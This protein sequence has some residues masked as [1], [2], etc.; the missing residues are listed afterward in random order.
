ME[1]ILLGGDYTICFHF[2]WHVL[3]IMLQESNPKL[4]KEKRVMAKLGI[5]LRVCCHNSTEG[6]THGSTAKVCAW[7]AVRG[8]ELR[9]SPH[10]RGAISA[11]SALP[12]ARGE[13]C[14]VGSSLC[15]KTLFVSDCCFFSTKWGWEMSPGVQGWSWVLWAGCGVG[16][17][18][19]WAVFWFLVLVISWTVQT[20]ISLA[21]CV[22]FHTRSS[23]SE[24]IT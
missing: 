8:W 4:H 6:F 9:C 1:N 13:G 12:P 5:Q 10:P 17:L 14:A 16:L 11:M 22:L 20:S 23:C 19:A 7:E 3:L 18:C 21:V 24:Q 2:P 15:C